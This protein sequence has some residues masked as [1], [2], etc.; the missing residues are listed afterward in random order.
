M[1]KGDFPLRGRTVVCLSTIDWGFLWQGHQEIMSRLAAAENR[2]VFV[3]NTGVRTVRPSDLGRVVRHLWRWLGQTAGAGRA[4]LPR[5]TLVA[6]LLLPFPRS[7]VALAVNERFLL[8]RL[9]RAITT[10]GDRDPIIFSYLPT[11]N[12]LRLINLVRGPRSVVVYYCVADFLELSD[13]GPA[14][15]ETERSLA[16]MADLVFVQGPE[17]GRRLAGLNP[18]IHEFRAGVNMDVF[19]PRSAGPPPAEVAALPRPVIGYSGG[20]H[21]HV[22]FALLRE[23]ARAFP[24]GSLVLVGP[25]Q[26]DP[27]PLRDEPN[28]RFLGVRTQR[29]L[30]PIVGAFDVGIV[31]YVRSDYTET[32][33]PTKLFEYL[34]M[35]RPVVATALPEVR[36]LALPRSALRVADGP[37][38]FIAAIAEALADPTEDA[39]AARRSLAATRDWAGI[40]REMATL[41]AERAAAKR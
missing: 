19:D 5:I 31:P 32:V 26:V 11:R 28:V 40:V 1:S 22:D 13:L 30:A 4:P 14:I 34:A 21:R 2:V 18:R 24:H 41:I 25:M 33:Y 29:D 6:P 10:H 36:K 17:L 37:A 39:E 15:V 8:P 27:G 9:A 3:E 35:G 20:I 23:I 12:A 16:R 38:A 7:R